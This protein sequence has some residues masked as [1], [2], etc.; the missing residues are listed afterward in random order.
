MTEQAT[1]RDALAQVTHEWRDHAIDG[2]PLGST[3]I[4]NCYQYADHVLA[5]RFIAQVRAEAVRTVFDGA[6]L[7]WSSIDGL[8]IWDSQQHYDRGLPRPLVVEKWLN[9]RADRIEREGS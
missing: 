4:C 1:V 8:N 6:I 9:R 7:S 5:S 2:T 3:P